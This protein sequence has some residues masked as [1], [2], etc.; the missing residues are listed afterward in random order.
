M[1]NVSSEVSH[2]V[3]CV[4][5]KGSQEMFLNYNIYQTF[6]KIRIVMI[7]DISDQIKSQV[8]SEICKQIKRD[9]IWVSR[10]KNQ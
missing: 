8:W 4:F 1:N 5:H 6:S 9:K 3:W 7:D 10:Q 2:K